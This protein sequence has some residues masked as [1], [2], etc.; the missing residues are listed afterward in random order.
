M[1]L[2]WCFLALARNL[3]S[4]VAA[5]MMLFWRCGSDMWASSGVGSDVFW[6]YGLDLWSFP[7]VVAW[8]GFP[9]GVAGMMFSGV[10]LDDIFWRCGLDTRFLPGVGFEYIYPQAL[11]E[12]EKANMYN[13]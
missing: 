9:T 7:G 8:M 5:W 3:V 2:G 10:G 13:R 11:P 6:C 12:C 1:W 4:G